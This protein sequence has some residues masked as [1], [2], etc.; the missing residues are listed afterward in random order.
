[1]PLRAAQARQIY[2]EAIVIDM[3]NDLPSKVL[4]EGYDP[5]VRHL[6]EAGHTDVPRLIESGLTAVW[7]A[8]WVDAPF[9][10]ASPI[11]HTSG[12]WRRSTSSRRW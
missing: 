7:L 9:S 8:A 6:P 1:M 5:S 3:H 2:D 10:T 11:D 12:R 4:E